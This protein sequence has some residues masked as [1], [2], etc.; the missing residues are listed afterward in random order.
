MTAAMEFCLL[1]PVRVRR[2]A[3][4]LPVAAGHQRAVLA[5][6]LLAGGRVVPADELAGVL[7]GAAPPASARV[8]VQNYVR[9]L[10]QALGEAGR[11]R[12][13]TRPG[14]YRIQVEAGELDVARFEGLAGDARAAARDGAW[15]A[16]AELA[17]TALALWRG[18]PLADAGS[19]R[20]L[21]REVPRLAELRRQVLATR[22]EA[23]LQAGRLDEVIA[24]LRVL[25]VDHPLLERL[26][27]L[28]M[29][30]LHRAGRPDEALAAYQH[31]RR[32]L[33]DELGTE[34]GAELQRL[35]REVLAG[36]PAGPAGSP[37]V[38][39]GPVVPRQLPG[40]VPHWAGRSAE[41]AALTG[42]LD[43]ADEHAPG[44]VVISAIGGTAGVGKTALAV[45]WGHQVSD[46]FP[47]GQL[48]VNLRGYDPDQPMTA[49]AALA[50][51]LSALGSPGSDIPAGEDE[52][53]ARYRSLLAGRRLLVILDNAAE[54][55]QVEPL[56]PGTPGCMVVVTSRDALA[57]LVARCGA[58]RLEL[59]LLPLD[60][61]VGL[62]R[63]LIGGR[64]DADP[65]VAVA[66]AE[67]CARLPLA[68]RVA[69]ELA[70]AR[71]DVSLA[72]LCSE[73]GGRQRRLD[74]LDAGGDPRTAVRAVFSWS[75]KHLDA[76]AARAFRLLG[77]HPG[78]SLDTFA[79]AAITG[80]TA[81]TATRLLGRL[82]RAYLI[83]PAGPGRYGLQRPAA[84]LRCRAGRPR[85]DRAGPAGRRHPAAR[86]LPAHRRGRDRHA[87]PRRARPPSPHAAG[88]RPGPARRQSRCGPG[89][90][91]RGTDRPGH[92]GRVRGCPRLAPARRPAV[93]HL[94]PLPRDRR[95]SLRRRHRPRAGPPGRPPG[96]R[97]LG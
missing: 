12:I 41:L 4:E 44:T 25:T 94:V 54:A 47:D 68:L 7:W 89:V 31:A 56:L 32:V 97:P 13:E 93:A 64:V 35:Q 1:G 14:G 15:D 24:E 5:A 92:G 87:L 50:G 74:L 18:E 72:E 6:L 42:L 46:R 45:R 95:P 8:S 37:V 28:L 11:D 29:L 67:R 23:D 10:R 36:V 52:R 66:L 43:R 62:L 17:R 51:F 27:A 79:A 30:A 57:G 77:L 16:A 48:Y 60:D 78:P 49:A 91:G 69:A 70:A 90:A 80:T 63:A 88:R 34:P 59:G 96:R 20:L 65:G 26:H 39:A 58:T 71:P 3:A 84:Q 86:L 38:G 76:D 2:G 73:L 33:A 55:G 19:E 9:R 81:G 61:A 22:I 83:Q 40:A 53:A 82:A 75:C 21:R 85:R